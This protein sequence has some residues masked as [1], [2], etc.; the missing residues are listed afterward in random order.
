[1][2]YVVR[3]GRQIEVETIQLPPRPRH[4]AF[5]PR[6]VQVPR[7]SQKFCENIRI[8]P[9]AGVMAALL[10][11]GSKIPPPAR[12]QGSAGWQMHSMRSGIAAHVCTTGIGPTPR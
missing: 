2:G 1:M 6:F 4:K 7:H 3:Y 9:T 11:I 8:M 10:M 5:E 12:S